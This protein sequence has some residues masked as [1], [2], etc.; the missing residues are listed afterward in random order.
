LTLIPYAGQERRPAPSRV[1][2]DPRP[3]NRS[4]AV[5]RRLRAWIAGTPDVTDRQI[6]DKI[7][8]LIFQE[9]PK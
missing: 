3:P 2:L 1:K 6:L 8:D 7:D 9:T 5:L 4:V